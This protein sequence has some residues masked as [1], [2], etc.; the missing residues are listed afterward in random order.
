MNNAIKK[1]AFRLKDRDYDA[2]LISSPLNITYL[3]NFRTAE[4]YL[5]ITSEGKLTYFTNFLYEQEAKKTNIWKVVV[6]NGKNIFNC[7]ANEINSQKLKRVGFEAKNIPFLEYKKI[8]EFISNKKIKLIPASDIVEEIRSIKSEDELRKIKKAISISQEAFEFIKTIYQNK[9]SEK[10]LC[11]EIEKFLKLKGDNSIA[12][13]PIVAYDE[14][15]SYPHHLPQD[16]I[17]AKEYILI[18]LGAK[19]LNYCA[20]LTRIFLKVT[21]SP[22]YKKI[23]DIVKYAQDMAIKKIKDGVAANEVDAIAREYIESKGYGKYFGHGLGHGIGLDVHEAPFLNP[24][25][26]KPLKENMVL[27]IEPAIYLNG[28]FGIRLE[29]IICVRANKAEILSRKTEYYIIE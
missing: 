28:N 2:F 13:S 10:D 12:F 29:D 4:G 9:M 17:C 24:Y 23:L 21:I 5:L 3:S 20:D 11:I 26:K 27:T 8:C 1:C 18:D 25:N 6:S 15:S 19:Y 14:N 7:I 16:K 22:L